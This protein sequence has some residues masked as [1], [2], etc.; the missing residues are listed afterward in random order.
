MRHNSFLARS[1]CDIDGVLCLDPT[2]EENDDGAGYLKFLNEV[3]P[4]HLPTVE[5][6][7]LVTSRLE[8]YRR[9]TEAW[10][11]RHGVRYKRLVMAPYSS[12]TERRAANAHARLKAEVYLASDCELFLESDPRIAKEIFSITHKPV[13]CV[14][15]MTL[16]SRYL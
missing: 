1:C 9:D 16:L 7:T 15:N 12:M 4:L 11:D 14:G 5:I 6:H 3:S 8:K 2:E 13:L 10:L